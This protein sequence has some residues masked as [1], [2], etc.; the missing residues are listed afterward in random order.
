MGIL[1]ADRIGQA[2]RL[3]AAAG[4]CV[5]LANCAASNKLS[6]R[7]DPKYGVSSSPRVVEFGE[8]VPKGGGAY[9]V[10][11]PYMVAGRQY[12]PEE[13]TNYRAE[14]MASWYGDDFHGRLTANGEV[15][16]M[17][18]LTA[19]HPTL[20]MPSYVRV[21]N[22]SNGKS[23]VVRVNDRGPYHGNRVIDV[24]HNAARLLG[25]RSTGIA[26]VRVEYV[27]RAPLEGSD[28][29]ILEATLRT[30]EPA[31]AP[32]AV[33][34]ASARPFVPDLPPAGQSAPVRGE[35]PLPAE[36]PYSL[37][38]TAQ[39]VASVSATSEMSAA[40]SR[41]SSGSL[42]NPRQVTYE[43]S[44]EPAPVARPVAAYAPPAQGRSQDGIAT[45]LSGRGLY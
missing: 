2:A 45:L 3:A 26:R 21:T 1:K 44:A 10:G 38:N 24:S 20:P 17:T 25:F 15:F 39:D 29:R 11:K 32:S 12:V 27:G 7:L 23:L 14:G 18:S 37:G 8:P 6:S 34:V 43:A 30:G 16:D 22:L 35:V 13:N 31:P 41:R 36:R 33:R 5:V 9:R 28:D 40:R 19:A 42:D 4:A